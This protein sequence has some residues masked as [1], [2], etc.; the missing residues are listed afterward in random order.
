MK[1]AGS[2]GPHAW[3]HA[4][5]LNGSQA[6]SA[7]LDPHIASPAAQPLAQ[8]PAAHT[9]PDAHAWP[10]EPQFALSVSRFAHDAVPLQYVVPPPQ[11]EL[12]APPEHAVPALQTCPHEPQFAPFVCILTLHAAPPHAA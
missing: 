8:A 3:P 5:Q 12:Q 1:H 9:W 6:R 7:Q 2:D 4:P 10:H 11:I